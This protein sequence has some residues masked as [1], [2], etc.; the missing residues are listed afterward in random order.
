NPEIDNIYQA[1]LDAGA[2]GG[3]ILG[4][5]GG[6]FILFFAK[7]EVQPKIREKLK[8]LIQVPFK[9]EPTGSKIVLYEPNGFI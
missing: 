3:K 5:G 9:F 7:P 8:H 4:A 6:G 2:T 1:G